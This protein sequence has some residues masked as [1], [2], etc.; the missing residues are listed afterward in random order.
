MTFPSPVGNT[1]GTNLYKEPT[2]E[3]GLKSLNWAKYLALGT[4]WQTKKQ[5]NMKMNK[6]D[7]ID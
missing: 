3:I 2:R 7:E 5:W 1:L 4:T 6:I